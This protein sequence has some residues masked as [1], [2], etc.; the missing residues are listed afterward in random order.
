[1][2]GFGE[3]QLGPRVLTIPITTLQ[4]QDSLNVACTSGTDVTTCDPNAGTLKDRD[5]EPRPLGGNFVVEGSVEARFPVWQQLFGAVFV[6][7][8]MVSQRTNPTLPKKRTAV[9]PGFGFRYRSPVGPI[10]A[11]IG[12]NPGATESLP[13]VTESIV[14]GQKTLVTLQKRRIYAPTNGHGV[15]GRMVLHLSIGEAF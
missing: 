7:A 13:V 6:D 15:L 5:F 10:R 8:G 4:S 3:N 2:R 14:N 12:F 9:T 11:D 1:V